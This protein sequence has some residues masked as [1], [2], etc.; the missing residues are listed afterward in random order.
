MAA[1]PTAATA[2]HRVEEI[3]V[4]ADPLGRI[5]SHLAAPVSVL[6][7]EALGRESMRSIGE[8]VANQPGVNS[9]D[10]GASVGRP[11]IRGLGGARVRVLEDG[12]GS[13]D[14]STLSPDHG[15]AVEPISPSDRDSGPATLLYGSG[16]SGGL[17]NV[18]TGAFRAS[19]GRPD[20]RA[21][22]TT[23]PPRA[24]GWAPSGRIAAGQACWRTSTACAAIPAPW[25]PDTPR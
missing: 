19:A 8:T 21:S 15:V 20:R 22:G 12:I 11:I 14:V 7:R 3:V 18:V 16:A 25:H 2:P 9:S 6:D 17:V 5:E 24:A 1:P 4:T 23:I 10:F 13:M